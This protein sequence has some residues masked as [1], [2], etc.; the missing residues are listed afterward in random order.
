VDKKPIFLLRLAVSMVFMPS[1]YKSRTLGS[2]SNIS[3][4]KKRMRQFC[5]KSGGGEGIKGPVS[6]LD[7]IEL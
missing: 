7:N 1:S 4:G 3:G 6:P 2:W 5:A